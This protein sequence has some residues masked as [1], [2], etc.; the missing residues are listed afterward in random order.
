MTLP[1]MAQQLPAHV[2]LQELGLSFDIP[3]GWVGQM[4]ED[5]IIMGHHH[6]PGM[7]IVFE[8]PS[9]NSEEMIQAA[10][11]GIQEPGIQ[12][13][14]AGQIKKVNQMRIEGRFQGSFQN[15]QVTAFAIGM[16]DGMGKGLSVFIITAQNQFSDQHVQAVQQLA[17]SV[18]FF[19]AQDSPTT[20]KWKQH[21]MGNQLIYMNTQGGSDYSGGYSGTSTTHTIDLCHNGQFSQYNNSHASFSHGESVAG[22]MGH[23]NSN[24]NQ[25]GTY[26]IYTL[27]GESVLALEFSNGSSTEYDLSVSAENHTML[28]DTRYFVRASEMCQ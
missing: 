4:S 19:Q 20:L 2:E 7:M 6:M 28:D 24:G 16:I 1:A 26:E 15:N 9:R 21:L 12:L 27:A 8:N 23:V 22:G 14:P 13:L 11:Q 3:S 18:Q 5:A 17:N 10:K 25:Q